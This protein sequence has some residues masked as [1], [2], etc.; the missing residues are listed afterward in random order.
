LSSVHKLFGRRRANA[1]KT[2]DVGKAEYNTCFMVHDL[3]DRRETYDEQFSFVVEI[4][5]D[6]PTIVL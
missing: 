4:Y 2:R 3:S 1:A 5:R 6:I